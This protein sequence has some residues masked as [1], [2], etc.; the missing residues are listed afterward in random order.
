MRSAVKLIQSD[1]TLV[2]GDEYLLD[3]ANPLQ[4]EAFAV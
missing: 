3:M 2:L 1:Q 4:Q